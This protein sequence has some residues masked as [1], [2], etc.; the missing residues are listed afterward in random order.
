MSGDEIAGS[1]HMPAGPIRATALFAHCFTCSKN[2]K[3][4]V[5]IGRSLAEQGIAVL[6]FDFTG[7]G[8]SGGDFSEQSFSSNAGDLVAAASF[9]RETYSAPKVLVGHSLGGAAVLAAA[10]DI[11]ECVAVA[12]IGAPADPAHV[13]HL[14]ADAKPEIEA[15]G[16]AEVTIAGRSFRIKKQFLEDL[17]NH[18]LTERVGRMRRALLVCHGP[19]DQIVGIDNARILF[20]AA[21]HPKSFLSLDDADH[22]LTHRVDADYVASV[23]ASWAARFL[24]AIE[25]QTSGEADVIVRGTSASFQ[26]YVVAGRHH[27]GADEPSSVAGGSDSGPTPYQLLLA[28]LGA[29]TS[30]TLKMYADHKKL[31]LESVEVELHHDKVHA[32]DCKECTSTTGMV[33]HIR[34]IV[35]ISGDLDEAQRKRMMEIADKCPVHRTL[36]REIRVLSEEG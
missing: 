9:M 14:I 2:L 20:E 16:E 31:P 27:F 18:A 8:E 3:A 36:H 17:E 13:A 22:L 10:E 24:P 11:P 6:R 7:L 33:D 32:K 23:V 19:R 26:Q 4:A 21:K 5:T 29:C 28:A 12:T 35:R 34:R 1:L 25:E 15:R 30:M